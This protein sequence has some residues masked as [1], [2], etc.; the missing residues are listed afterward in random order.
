MVDKIE[1]LISY[2]SITEPVKH[3]AV[4]VTLFQELIINHQK[5]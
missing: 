1:I 3:G 5:K 2:L 4:V